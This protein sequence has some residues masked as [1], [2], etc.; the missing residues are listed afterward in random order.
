MTIPRHA[1]LSMGRPTTRTTRKKGGQRDVGSEMGSDELKGDPGSP[2]TRELISQ[3]FHLGMKGPV[4]KGEI[5][6]KSMM[7]R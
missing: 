6:R 2:C 4:L 3:K 1:Y 5:T 7:A